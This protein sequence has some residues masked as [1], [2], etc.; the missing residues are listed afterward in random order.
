MSG[1]PSDPRKVACAHNS[2]LTSAKASE[3]V[4]RDLRYHAACRTACMLRVI[5]WWANR[6]TIENNPNSAGVVLRIASSDHCLCVS[7]P[8]C[9]RASWKVVSICQRKTNHPTICSG[10]A[11]RSVQSKAWVANSPCGSRTKTQRMGTAG[12]PVL[13]QSTVAEATSTVRSPLPYQSSTVAATQTVEGSSATAARFGSRSPFRRGLPICP[14]LR[15][16]AGSNRV[17]RPA[18]SE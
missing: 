17:L 5:R 4:G 9:R 18:S 16:G 6:V 1:S 8:R 2:F 7:M 12:N 15:G 11:P 3:K 14:A 10:L 13:Y